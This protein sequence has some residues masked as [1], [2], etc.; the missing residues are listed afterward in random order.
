MVD[1]G[2]DDSNDTHTLTHAHSHVHALTH[3][4]SHIH[5]HSHMLTHV[6][7]HPCMHTHAYTHMISFLLLSNCVDGLRP[8]LVCFPVTRES[9]NPPKES[10]GSQIF[11]LLN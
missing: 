9:H 11:S 7:A 1:I 10:L 8:A 3:A 4:H 2:R 5:L 6:G